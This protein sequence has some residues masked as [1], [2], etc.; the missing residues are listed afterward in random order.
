MQRMHTPPHDIPQSCQVCD[1][2]PPGR[3][4][5]QAAHNIQSA[6]FRHPLTFSRVRTATADALS[7]LDCVIYTPCPSHTPHA[8][9]P[10]QVD[11]H[12]RLLDRPRQRSPAA[13]QSQAL[14]CTRAAWVP[15]GLLPQHARPTPNACAA[16]LTSASPSASAPAQLAC[17]T[18]GACAAALTHAS[19][20]SASAPAPPAAPAAPR[21]PAAAAHSPPP[22]RQSTRPRLRPG[23]PPAAGT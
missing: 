22:P 13:Q 10:P 1:T 8:R 3:P 6:C 15:V 12:R 5:A 16:A 11:L 23:W 7:Q 9:P 19:P 17:S 2:L 21:P 18:S 14:P 20:P 4:A